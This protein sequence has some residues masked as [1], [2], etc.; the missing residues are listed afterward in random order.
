MV[1]DKKPKFTEDLLGD[2]PVSAAGSTTAGP[3]TSSATAPFGLPPSPPPV[4]ELLPTYTEV[5]TGSSSLVPTGPLVPSATAA[6]GGD[7][8]TLLPPSYSIYTPKT[9]SHYLNQHVISYDSHINTSPEAL[10]QFLLVENQQPPRQYVQIRGSHEV[11]HTHWERDSEGRSRTRTESRS[12]TDFE[13]KIDLTSGLWPLVQADVGLSQEVKGRLEVLPDDQR[14]YRG[15]RVKARWSPPKNR[16]KKNG[17]CAGRRRRRRLQQ[18]QQQEEGGLDSE[19]L[20]D[21]SAPLLGPEEHT[22]NVDH[23]TVIPDSAVPV[24]EWA[25]RYCRLPTTCKEFILRKPVTNLDQNLLTKLITNAV[26][27]TGY[28]GSVYV[29]FPKTHHK[30]AIYPDTWLAR[31]R[32][33]PWVRWFFYLTFLWII[34]WPI[35][36]LATRKFHIVVSE[37]EWG[38]VRERRTVQLEGGGTQEVSMPVPEESERVWA[39]LWKGAVKMAAWRKRHDG[40]GSRSGSGSW[41]VRFGAGAGGNGG[42][43]GETWGADEDW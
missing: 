6:A 34:S 32:Q 23:P 30:V 36:Y 20:D 41:C 26:R 5:A 33:N 29:S 7:S 8:S 22:D 27:D 19:Q 3:S 38:F 9:S 39:G 17:G 4:D 25:E 28:R 12:V 16:G 37:W 40:N 21:N 13:F 11:R 35:L 31:T 24:R 42:A 15:G 2:D 43:Y 1:A 10:Y 14:V 18:Q